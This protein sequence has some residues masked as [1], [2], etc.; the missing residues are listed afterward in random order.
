VSRGL[1]APTRGLSFVGPA[2]RPPISFGPFALPAL[3]LCAD[4]KTRFALLLALASWSALLLPAQQSCPQPPAL[5]KITGKNIFTDQQEID[6]GDAMGE[7]FAREFPL[8]DDP[9]L[10]SH[11]EA[12]GARLANFLPPNNLR[13]RFFLIDTPEV[14]AYSLSG[15]RI[16]VTRKMV[17]LDRS[18]DELAGVLAHE[19][20]HI[21]THQHAIAMTRALKQVLG[22]TQVGDRADI[23]DK[24]HRL[25]EN[26]RRNP[27][28][29]TAERPENEYIA[30]QVALF[31][32]A[33]AG[34][35]PQ[36]YVDLWDRFNSTHGKTGSWFSDF[37][38][39][40]KPE[41]RRLRELLKSVSAMPPECARIT[42][43]SSADFE[44]WQWQVIGSGA[45]THVE[46]LPG[47]LVRQKLSQPLRPD[48]NN[49]HFSP[50]GK[51]VLAQDDGGI[52]VLSRDPFQF[53]FFIEAPNADKAFFSPDSKAVVFKTPA[54]RVE[55]WDVASQTRTSVHEMLLRVGCIQSLLSPDGSYLACL[56]RQ[57]TLSLFEVA[58]GNELASKKNFLQIPWTSFVWMYVMFELETNS[59][60]K[61]AHLA[62]SPDDHYFLAGTST[63]TFAYDLVAKRDADLPS[64]IR[65][66]A[67]DEFTF[68]DN[69]RVF[70]VNYRSPEKCPLLRFPTGERLREVVLARG[71]QLAPA[72]HGDYV[73]VGP[74]K[75]GKLGFLELSTG[76]LVVGLQKDAGDIYDNT[77]VFEEID[78][79]IVLA[80]LP[81]KKIVARAQLTQSRLGDN[82][83][84]AASA[85]FNWLAASTGSRGAVWDLVHDIRVH[86]VRGFTAGWFA[87]DDSFY[88]DFPKLDTQDRAVVHLD[89]LG[90]ATPIFPIGELLAVQEGAYLLV[91]T[92]ARDNP[93]APKN[94][95]Y[96]LRD[97][98]SKSTLWSR[99]FP[100]EPP[101]MA[102]SAN[103]N[104]VL[105]G[106]R[107]SADAAHDEMKQYPELKGSADKEDMFYELVDLHSSAVLGK[108]VVK[109]NKF[110]FSVRYVAVDGDSVA[111]QV[112]GDRVLTYSLASGKEVGHVF[113][114]AP[115]ISSVAGAYAVSTAE[116]AVNVYD[117]SKSRLRQSYK[118]PVSVVYKKFSLDGK[119][120]LVLTRDQTVY[121]LDLAASSAD[122]S[123]VHIP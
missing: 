78:G 8:I 111:L 107:V 18:D 98:R 38:E 73:A 93:H 62:F 87:D 92:P 56:D 42:P 51:F 113:G 5:Q 60:F 64:S 23:F 88:A 10:T 68:V 25:L 119:R 74:L 117:L 89:S 57:F 70:A 33:R 69:G 114:Y 121:V 122:V 86:H 79:R 112:S 12:L 36:P 100:Q 61:L 20:G 9:A 49:L 104:A 53:L 17:A 65:N 11:L 84:I 48:I 120:L 59:N 22:V 58:T 76:H 110:S 31:A 13:F 81:S 63:D 85:D 80:E 1:F 96:D 41:Q 45:H 40:T 39:T 102:F 101:S 71:L 28:H 35:A 15:G 7:S 21:V 77:V 108:L 54:L 30:D 47:L 50:D 115:V 27:T 66:L 14:N 116:G 83:A 24:F 91:R 4:M 29:V 3:N 32:M 55:I 94:W 43:S 52:H 90:N 75:S 118:F 95:T 99:H 72:A 103:D 19:M 97:F 37:F 109:T 67:H 105:M 2:T 16:Y 46:S 6:L 34:F 26:R 82:R 44:S 106:W 123:D